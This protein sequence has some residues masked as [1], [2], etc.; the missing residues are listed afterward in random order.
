MAYVGIGAPCRSVVIRDGNIM[1]QAELEG[2]LKLGAVGD[3]AL[4]YFDQDGR[5]ICGE[6]DERVIGITLEELK[7]IEWVVGVA[8]GVEKLQAIRGA[9]LGK[10]VN[11]LITD[12]HTAM[13]LLRP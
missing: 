2:L 11:V 10:N 13:E 5:P 7:K 1:S 8:G 9:L 12:Q 4:R 3:I 6:L